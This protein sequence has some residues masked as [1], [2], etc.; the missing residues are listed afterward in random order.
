MKNENPTE[1]TGVD[2]Y[3]FD[4]LLKEDIF[5]FP[6]GKSLAVNHMSEKTASTQEKFSALFD[7]IRRIVESNE[8]LLAVKKK[9]LQQ[10]IVEHKDQEL[11]M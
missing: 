2:S 9:Q 6:I 11:N 1:F 10:K 3:V 8:M 7:S 5:W 4:M